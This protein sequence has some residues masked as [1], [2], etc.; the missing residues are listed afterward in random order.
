[1]PTTKL[2][3]INGE[4]WGRKSYFPLEELE[5]VEAGLVR[6]PILYRLWN[7]KYLTNSQFKHH[8]S[9]QVTQTTAGTTV[10]EKKNSSLPVLS[11]L[12]RTKTLM[13]LISTMS[14]A[15]M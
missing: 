11:T 7:F 9:E 6:L 8:L 13:E 4:A 5:W 10:L 15:M 14:I 1:M 12:L 2:W 3:L